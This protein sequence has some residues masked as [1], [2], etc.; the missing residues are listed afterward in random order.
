MGTWNCFYA[1]IFL[2]LWDIYHKTLT[3][4]RGMCNKEQTKNI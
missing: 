2:I 1:I 4:V 3:L